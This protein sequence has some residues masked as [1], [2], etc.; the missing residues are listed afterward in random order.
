MPLFSLRTRGLEYIRSNACE[1]VSPIDSS[2]RSQACAQSQETQPA[3][4]VHF[5]SCLHPPPSPLSVSVRV[6]VLC[7]QSSGLAF[8]KLHLLTPVY[9]PHRPPA[10]AFTGRS[11]SECR[12]AA[13]VLAVCEYS[14]TPLMS[15]I[16]S[17]IVLWHFLQSTSALRV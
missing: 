9:V 17:T 16:I 10:S 15:F 4:M 6:L 14:P 8:V 3:G 1:D 7:N 12:R 13:S 2:A 5:L 11:H